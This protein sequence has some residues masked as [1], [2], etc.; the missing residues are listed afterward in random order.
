ML[1]DKS[2]STKTLAKCPKDLS[3]GHLLVSAS[4]RKGVPRQ[5]AI[6]KIIL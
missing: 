4:N 5:L 2:I 1:A 3:R 6:A